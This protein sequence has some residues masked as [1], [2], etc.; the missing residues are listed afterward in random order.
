M[1]KRREKEK[2]K[3]REKRE[4]QQGCY[5]WGSIWDRICRFFFFYHFFFLNLCMGYRMWDCGALFGV[6]FVTFYLFIIFFSKF[7]C[8]LS[9]MCGRLFF[10][11]F[12]NCSCLIKLRPFKLLIFYG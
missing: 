1:K 5:L 10:Q 3:R 8:G 4:E 11:F 7:V 9:P 12:F 2:N 6:R